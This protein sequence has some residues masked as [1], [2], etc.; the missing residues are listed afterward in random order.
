MESWLAGTRDHIS[1]S[2]QRSPEVSGPNGRL[3]GKS[4]G[5]LLRLFTFPPPPRSLQSLLRRRFQ[6]R[7]FRRLEEAYLS[8]P[9]EGAPLGSAGGAARPGYTYQRCKRGFWKPTPPTRTRHRLAPP[10]PTGGEVTGGEERQRKLPRPPTVPEN[11]PD[12]SLRRRGSRCPGIQGLRRSAGASA[13]L[14]P[15]GLTCTGSGLALHPHSLGL[16]KASLARLTELG[17]RV[18]RRRPKARLTVPRWRSGRQLQSRTI[19]NWSPPWLPFP[20]LRGSC[21]EWRQEQGGRK[22]EKS[23]YEEGREGILSQHRETQTPFFHWGAFP[24]LGYT[25]SEEEAAGR[26][27][28]TVFQFPWLGEQISFP[29]IP[30]PPSPSP[31]S[32]QV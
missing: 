29:L 21:Q 1:I 24:S 10:P 14:A 27:G 25:E 12:Q 18:E 3:A 8:F 31:H 4:R 5:T 13:S 2:F 17:W 26:G 32:T 22:S 16:T 6:A 15:S 9:E 11:L 28:G 20:F 23:E 19:G 7:P 30:C